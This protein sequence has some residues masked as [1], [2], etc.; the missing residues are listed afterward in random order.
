MVNYT[1]TGITDLLDTL[2]GI[3]Y[4]LS[5][6][7]QFWMGIWNSNNLRTVGAGTEIVTKLEELFIPKFQNLKVP[8]YF[9]IL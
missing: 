1:G 8:N 4:W 2:I 9:F 3:H 6:I 7:F 5:G